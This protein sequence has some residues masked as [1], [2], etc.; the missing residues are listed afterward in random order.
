MKSLIYI[1]VI[2]S[3]S[4]SCVK[5][6]KDLRD[7]ILVVTD[8]YGPTFI[9]KQTQDTLPC[10]EWHTSSVINMFYDSVVIEYNIKEMYWDSTSKIWSYKNIPFTK[11]RIFMTEDENLNVQYSTTLNYYFMDTV[12]I[13]E[14]YDHFL[15]LRKG[16]LELEPILLSKISTGALTSPPNYASYD[17]YRKIDS[18]ES[19]IENLKSDELALNKILWEYKKKKK[20]AN[21]AI[22]N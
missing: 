17:T 10:G 1:L 21:Y 13:N 22:W 4:L 7:R 8:N 16:D 18:L 15:K 9:D 3:F 14:V 12:A 5:N 20:I 2:V 19:Y 11:R 6:K